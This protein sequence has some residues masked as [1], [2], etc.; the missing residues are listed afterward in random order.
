MTSRLTAHFPTHGHGP[1]A[2]RTPTTRSLGAALLLTTALAACS[3]TPDAA[4]RGAAPAA[5]A[6]R[7]GAPVVVRDT[8]LAADVE[9]SGV[10]EPLRQAMLSSKLMGTVTVVHVREGD[11]VRA[12]QAL[13]EIDA[14]DLSA[15]ATQAA[16]GLADARAMHADATTQA[17]RMRAL[18]A[19]SA[20]TQAQY[21][22]AQT[23]LARAAAAVRAAEGG[24]AEVES[25]RSYATV[26]APFGGVVTSRMAD[27]GTFAAPGAPM[28]TVQDV[29]SLRIAASAGGDV[30]RGIRRG[31]VL[32]ATIGGDAVT[33]TVEGVV[34]GTVGNLFTV[35]A[36]VANAAGSR[37]AGSSAVLRI[38]GAPQHQ[39]LVPAAAIVR[40]GDLTGVTVRGTT[41]DEV[42]WVRLGAS[43]D[44]LVAVTSGLTAG[45]TIV[46][47]AA[48]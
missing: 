32:Q 5:E 38:P 20:A 2:H 28:L 9:L 12:G 35:N 36:L 33:A 19:D 22:A 43:R 39:V 42:R 41:R 6:R 24:V 31:Q 48:K 46:V 1:M 17:A 30:V 45:E 27:P 15:R 16:A 47:P 37:R 23:G 11:V 8:L 3:A 40:D 7:T 44:G 25:M 10:A 13:L 26:R 4:G 34:P 29:S 21:D 18:Y 14:R